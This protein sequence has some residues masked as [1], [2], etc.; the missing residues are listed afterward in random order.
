MAHPNADLLRKGFDAFA[1][2]DMATMDQL[3]A[4][5]A[6]WH[7]SGRNP[8]AGDFEGKEAIFESFA[9]VRQET[10]SLEQD[11]H[12][13]LADDEHAVALVNATVTRGGKTLQA[14]TFFVFHIVDGKATEV[15]NAPTDQY[16]VDEFWA[17]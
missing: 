10:D 1:T 6:K 13:M 16:A 5:D 4:D 2:G 7:S 15:W 3:I 12:A 11:V 17:S 8:L 14:Q 9:R